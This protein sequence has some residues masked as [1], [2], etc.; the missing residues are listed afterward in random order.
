VKYD[1]DG[2]LEKNLDQPPA[3]AIDIMAESKNSWLSAVGKK[4]KDDQAAAADAGGH[5]R[6]GRAKKKT[7]ASQF[8]ESL[9]VLMKNIESSQ[10]HFIRCIKP[11]SEGNI[12]GKY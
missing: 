12:R 2:W 6:G 1:C 7:V 11:N 5:G 4:I 8:K 3:E 9:A 10:P